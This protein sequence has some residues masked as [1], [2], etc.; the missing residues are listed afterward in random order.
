MKKPAVA[1]VKLLFVLKVDFFVCQHIHILL[2]ER[3]GLR[4]ILID[5][6]HHPLLRSLGQT[7]RH[8]S[9]LHDHGQRL[10]QFSLEGFLTRICFDSVALLPRRLLAWHGLHLRVSCFLLLHGYIP[11]RLRL[12]QNKLIAACATQ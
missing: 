12:R 6:V 3:W 11:V 2:R 10:L 9:L 4:L 8:D 5:R 1:Y 7:V